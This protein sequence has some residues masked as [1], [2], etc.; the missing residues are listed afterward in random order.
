MSLQQ[1][2]KYKQKFTRWLPYAVVL[3]VEKEFIKNFVTAN[4]PRPK[5]WGQ[6]EEKALDLS[7]D[8]SYVWVSANEMTARSQPKSTGA[9]SKSV[10]RRLGQSQGQSDLLKHIQPALKAF[11]EAGYNTFSKAPIPSSDREPE[12]L[13]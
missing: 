4:A 11:L 8:Q 10:I 2:E 6:P 7:P 12:S 13:S 1:A 9:S 3:G 5:W